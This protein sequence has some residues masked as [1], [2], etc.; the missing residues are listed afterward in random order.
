[1][2]SD[3]MET[4]DQELSALKDNI[5]KKGKNAYYYAHAHKVDGPKWDGK[6]EPKLLSKDQREVNSS[7]AVSRLS[8][9]DSKS[10]ITNY[11]FCDEE[12]KVKIYVNLE[13]VGEKCKEE[14]SVSIEFTENSFSL[15]VRN[16]AESG[17][18]ECLI[19]ARLF[20]R[21][22]KATY[23]LKANK[24]IVTLIKINATPWSRI[25]LTGSGG[26]S[27]SDDDDDDYDV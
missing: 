27:S 26:K 6:P 20:G 5:E 13:G 25:G 15:Y 24:I 9:F 7:S 10:T 4:N 23:K 2:A 12:K 11:A 14:G 17:A 3:E 18:D 21:I 19:F 1:M 16:F 22:K 8:S